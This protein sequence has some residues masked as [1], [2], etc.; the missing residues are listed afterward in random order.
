[1]DK[2]IENLKSIV[3]KSTI[4]TFYKSQTDFTPKNRYGLKNR[5]GFNWFLYQSLKL[6]GNADTDCKCDIFSRQ[7][8]KLNYAVYKLKPEQ[9]G[10]P[11]VTNI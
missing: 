4:K 6:H 3:S 10:Y 9:I 8:Y 5:H 1:M 2:A 11:K 7:K